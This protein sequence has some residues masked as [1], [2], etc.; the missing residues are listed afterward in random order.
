M[1]LLRDSRVIGKLCYEVH[2]IF[3]VS[4]RLLRAFSLA[5]LLID[6]FFPA[7]KGQAPRA[8]LKLIFNLFMKI[9]IN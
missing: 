6:Y 8:H 3:G 4:R 5:L 2:F 1:N 7:L 9:H